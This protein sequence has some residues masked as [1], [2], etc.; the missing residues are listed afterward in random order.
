VKLNGQR[1]VENRYQSHFNSRGMLQ[2][3]E[4]Y[5]TRNRSAGPTPFRT[6]R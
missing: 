6:N 5:R 3:M 2:A 1:V 4:N